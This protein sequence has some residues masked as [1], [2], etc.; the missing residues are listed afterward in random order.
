MNTAGPRNYLKRLN[1]SVKQ[2]SVLL[3]VIALL[4]WSHSILYARFEVGHF[5][6]IHGLPVTFLVALAFLTAASAILWVSQEDHG[7]LL[8]LQLVILI[9]ALWLVPGITGGSPP[10]DNHAY[11]SLGLIDHVAGQGHFSSSEFWYLSWP[12]AFILSTTLAKVLLVNFEPVFAFY[13]LFM[14]L[15]YLLPL[16]VF[17]KNTLGQSRSNY[18]WAGAW[19]FYLARWVGDNQLTPLSM[20]FFLMLTLLALV[21][22]SSLWERRP[23]SFPLL[24]L[25]V[26]TF[27]A[28]TITHLPTSVVALCILVAFCLVKRSKRL[29]LAVALCFVL[30]M[31][32]DLAATRYM[33]GRL[34]TQPFL[35]T[36]SE[37]GTVTMS[38]G[39]IV[40]RDISSFVRGSESHIAMTKI[41]L[42]FSAI[43]AIIGLIGAVLACLSKANLATAAPL[44]AI[45]LAPMLMLPFSGNY[46]TLLGMRVYLYC[47]PGMAYFGA[48]L[49]DIRKRAVVII[50]CLLLIAA[51][52]LHVISR[53]GNSAFDYFPA[54]QAAGVDFFRDKFNQNLY[55]FIFPM[56]C[57]YTYEQLQLAHQANGNFQNRI[58]ITHQDKAWADLILDDPLFMD[59]YLQS[60]AN[61]TNYDFIYNNP[62]FNLYINLILPH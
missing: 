51:F 62:D 32:W 33:I 16:Y 9:S 2:I 18:C 13:P 25:L 24:S 17:L 30:L 10:F 28:L 22:S 11:R 43:F 4:L 37:T 54:G 42:S 6:L 3:T 14:Q 59:E 47:L 57:R 29:A 44:L 27:A 31:C 52:P 1:W 34:G 7:K 40:R 23:K 49:L 26:L 36:S 45:T 60:L 20:A 56:G 19:L 61:N 41:K 39:E 55:L 48:R 8:C 5:G 12:G 50:L 53:Y 46:D 58:W 35:G 21:T 38:P 15:L